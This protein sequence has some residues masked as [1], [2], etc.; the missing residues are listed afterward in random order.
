MR[1]PIRHGDSTRMLIVIHLVI[2]DN[3][4]LVDIFDGSACNDRYRIVC[5]GS[6][7][8]FS[9]AKQPTSETRCERV[10]NDTD[11]AGKQP[12]YDFH[13][14]ETKWS[15]PYPR[16]CIFEH[17]RFWRREATLDLFLRFR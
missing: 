16:I 4:L 13:V 7:I 8:S 1:R 5:H 14:P 17:I 11:T 6:N 2:T 10:A 9:R 12:P 15:S 3:Q